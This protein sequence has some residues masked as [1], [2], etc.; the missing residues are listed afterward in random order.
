[1]KETLLFIVAYL[2]GSIP[3]GYLVAKANGVDIFKAGSGNVGAT[4]VMR[5]LGKK[6]GLL[7]FFLDF[8]KGL[9]MSIMGRLVFQETDMA[10]LCGVIAVAGHCLS[11]FLKFRGGKGIATGLGAVL[12]AVPVIALISLAGYGLFFITTRYVSLSSLVAITV[13]VVMGYVY[14][15][16]PIT[17][18][19]FWALWVL[20]FVRHKGNIQRLLKGEEPKFYAKSAKSEQPT[21]PSSSENQGESDA[22]KD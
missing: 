18:G 17:L 22:Q 5:T 9:S 14:K 12:G 20:I 11:P 4:N 3:V 15:E 7:V 21:E 19:V 16:D 13:T 8:L 1:M 2:I 6:W 10:I